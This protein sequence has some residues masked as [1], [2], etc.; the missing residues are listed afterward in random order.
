MTT[1]TID[2]LIF[3]LQVQDQMLTMRSEE[4]IEDAFKMR[5]KFKQRKEG[6]KV[7]S[8]NSGEVKSGENQDDSLRKGKISPCGICKK[9]NH[10]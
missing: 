4:I 2:E 3:K 8:D 5:H 6:S 1:L 10:L 9:T 7:S